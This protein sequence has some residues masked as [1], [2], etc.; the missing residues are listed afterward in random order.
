MLAGVY[1]F[2]TINALDYKPVRDFSGEYSISSKDAGEWISNENGDV[3]LEHLKVGLTNIL[4][5]DNSDYFNVV[6]NGA[7]VLKG[8]TG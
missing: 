3:F 4:V 5:K 6:I 1:R 8:E 2:R 7:K